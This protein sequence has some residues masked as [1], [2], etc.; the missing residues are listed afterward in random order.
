M[1]IERVQRYCEKMI[2]EER[3]KSVPSLDRISSFEQMLNFVSNADT[4]SKDEL[5]QI[6]EI[7]C[8]YHLKYKHTKHP[9]TKSDRSEFMQIITQIKLEMETNPEQYT[10]FTVA[11]FY[12]MFMSKMDDFWIANQFSPFALNKH[13][14]TILGKVK[15][16]A[17][18]GKQAG[19]YKKPS[20]QDVMR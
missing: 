11:S 17:A 8:S 4:P 16:N 18:G 9:I 13:F 5:A 12:E 3:M 6:E 15:S 7:F 14:R 20:Y 19:G 1:D 10:A 2:R